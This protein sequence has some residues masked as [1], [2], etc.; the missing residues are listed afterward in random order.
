MIASIIEVCNVT[1]RNQLVRIN[2][3][4]NILAKLIYCH[5]FIIFILNY[6]RI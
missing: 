2:E 1:T 4:I 3:A 5:F 6:A